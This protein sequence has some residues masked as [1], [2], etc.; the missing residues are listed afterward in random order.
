[1]NKRE[2]VSRPN[3]VSWVSRPILLG[4]ARPILLGEA[5]P[6][7]EAGELSS[8]YQKKQAYTKKKKT[9]IRAYVCAACCVRQKTIDNI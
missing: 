2:R 8:F 1:M 4:E 5:R 6:G 3:V 7:V 9:T